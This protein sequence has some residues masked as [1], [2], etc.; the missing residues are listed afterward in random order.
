MNKPANSNGFRFVASAARKR[1]LRKRGEAIF[2]DYNTGMW[3]WKSV[4]EEHE[5]KLL[6]NRIGEQV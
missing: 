3:V 5:L 1:K 2:Y 4:W 6:R